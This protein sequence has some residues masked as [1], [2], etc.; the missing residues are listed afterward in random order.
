MNNASYSREIPNYIL[1]QAPVLLASLAGLIVALRLRRKAPAASLWATAAFALG[2][3]TCGLMAIGQAARSDAATRFIGPVL[4]AT[5]YVLLL[6]GVYAGR[7]APSAMPTDSRASVWEGVIST[8]RA[9]PGLLVISRWLFASVFMV[10]VITTTLVT[11]I[12]PE[13]YVSTAKVALR[14]NVSNPAGMTV[15]QG[16]SGVFDPRSIQTE[17][18]VIQSESILGKVIADL[19]LNQVWGKQFAD[20]ERLRT[21]ETMALLRGRMDVWPVPRTSVIGIRIYGWK[22]DEAARIANSIAEVYRD[23]INA[24]GSAALIASGPR[25]EI[26]DFAVP[27]VRPVR[28]NRPLNIT[29]GVM[30]GLVL[31]LLVGAGTWWLGLQVGNKPG[32]NPRS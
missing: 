22:P 16:A 15:P 32:V 26:L 5:T 14:P 2:I 1:T 24:P 9:R 7:T 28:P 6:I 4:S 21:S 27:G 13:S 12:L 18:E 20:G 11:F 23:H 30:I 29:L 10:V 17:C 8:V 19:N 31:G 3:F 25:V